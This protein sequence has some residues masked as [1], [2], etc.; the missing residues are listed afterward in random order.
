[1]DKKKELQIEELEQV[2]AGCGHSVP[3]YN[4]H[5]VVRDAWQPSCS[6]RKCSPP[7]ARECSECYYYFNCMDR[8]DFVKKFANTPYTGYCSAQ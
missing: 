4:G 1:M 2:S 6:P 3:K 8:D 5:L 7:D